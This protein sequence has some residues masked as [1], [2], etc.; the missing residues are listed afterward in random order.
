MATINFY[1]ITEHVPPQP[2]LALT[3]LLNQIR[4]ALATKKLDPDET[5]E[6]INTHGESLSY[7]AIVK[8]CL[9]IA[10][11]ELEG[12]HIGASLCW[13]PIEGDAT[14]PPC[15]KHHLIRR[16]RRMYEATSNKA[17]FSQQTQ[18]LRSSLKLHVIELERVMAS[19][20]LEGVF[21]ELKLH[22]A[23][24]L[25]LRSEACDVYKAI[26]EFL[27]DWAETALKK[28]QYKINDDSRVAL[29]DAVNLYRKDT[30]ALTAQINAEKKRERHNKLLSDATELLAGIGGDA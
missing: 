5:L 16:C 12:Q 13:P 9:C 10:G 20:D 17:T 22:Y 29:K 18:D 15:S 3:E 4:L 8:A 2:A 23:E 11:A 27:P 19:H 24:A 1:A 6:L 28:F 26:P 30:H 7:F 14:H 25:A 21:N